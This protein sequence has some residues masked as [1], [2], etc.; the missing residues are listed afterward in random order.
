[1]NAPDKNPVPKDNFDMDNDAKRPNLW[2]TFYLLLGIGGLIFSIYSIVNSIGG[3]VPLF[4]PIMAS[5]LTGAIS[6]LF[7]VYG[8][9]VIRKDL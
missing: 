8:Y 6:M 2:G 5:V 7:I 3:T 4:G 9:R 1:M